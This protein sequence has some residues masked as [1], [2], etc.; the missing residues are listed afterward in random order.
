MRD[1]RLAVSGTAIIWMQ[2]K[3]MH[4]EILVEDASGKIVLESILEKLLGTGGETHTY[5]IFSY[6]G[7]GRIPKDLR[8]TIDPWKRILLD[9]LPKLLRGY[10]KSLQHFTTSVVVVVD[11]DDKDC[12]VFKQEMLDILN[13]CNPRPTTLFRIAIEESEAWMLGDR[14]AVRAAYP[15]AKE[16][17]LTEYVQ[18]SICGTWEKLADA[19]YPG[20]SQELKQ[21]GWPHTGRAKCE[22]ATNIAPHLD[23]DNNQSRSFQV[24]RDGIRN[25]TEGKA[26]A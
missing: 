18:D 17:V 6:K 25:L 23:V 12:L 21:L 11:L 22:W 24:F 26:K 10:G 13:A 7:I 1:C 3:P 9:R 19:V 8:G 14:N 20:G 16:R 4:F 5:R 2:G 15:R